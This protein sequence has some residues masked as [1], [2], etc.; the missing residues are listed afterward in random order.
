MYE[1]DVRKQDNES[2][3]NAAKNFDFM[4]EIEALKK[5]SGICTADRKLS[6]I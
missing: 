4:S 2:L 5:D 1:R 3:S 6:L